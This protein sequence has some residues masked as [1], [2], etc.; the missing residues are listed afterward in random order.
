MQGFT[1]TLT[2]Y[3]YDNTTAYFENLLGGFVDGNNF[4]PVRFG[5]K[6]I[7]GKK[8]ILCTV[9]R[10][11]KNTVFVIWYIICFKIQLKD[12]FVNDRIKTE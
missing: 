2:D 4:V 7:E 6:H 11:S 12:L 5:L 9:K 3:F 10:T 8:P 1:K